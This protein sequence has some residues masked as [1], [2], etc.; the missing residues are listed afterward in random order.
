MSISCAEICCV[1]R[2]VRHGNDVR[3]CSATA[4]GF[5][6]FPGMGGGRQGHRIIGKIAE[7]Y[8]EPATAQQVRD[9]FSLE[10]AT[11]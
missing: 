2:T 5:F 4:E 10:N 3:S 9:L 7:Q 6:H 11:T 1:A 8:L